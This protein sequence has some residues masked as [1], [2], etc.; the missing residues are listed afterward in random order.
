MMHANRRQ[1]KQALFTVMCLVF[2]ELAA[3]AA[4]GEPRQPSPRSRTAPRAALVANAA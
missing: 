3:F 2:P 4:C 1:A